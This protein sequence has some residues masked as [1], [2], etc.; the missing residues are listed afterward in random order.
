MCE[1][2]HSGDGF[3]KGAV[4]GVLVGAALGVLLAPEEGKKTQ[5]K[6]K[7]KTDQ[8]MQDSEKIMEAVDKFSK[9]YQLGDRVREA[10]KDVQKTAT[11]VKK[12]ADEIWTGVAPEPPKPPAQSSTKSSSK[13]TDSKS[14]KSSSRSFFKR[15]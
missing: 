3:F 15:S 8:L 4:L 6:L 5:E 11:V 2:N 7:R 10:S 13:K 1:H 12:K 9:Q 14:T